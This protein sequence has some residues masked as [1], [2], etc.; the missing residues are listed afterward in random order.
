MKRVGILGLFFLTLNLFHPP[1]FADDD[2]DFNPVTDAF[3]QSLEKL[4]K[5][6]QELHRWD[7]SVRGFRHAHNFSW[8]YSSVLSQ[9]NLDGSLLEDGSEQPYAEVYETN[10]D[11]LG[12]EY[13]FHLHLFD[14]FGY[15]LGSSLGFSWEERSKG[16]NLTI[17]KA[18]TFP[19]AVVGLSLNLSPAVRLLTDLSVNLTRFERFKEYRAGVG[20]SSKIYFNART[21]SWK[22]GFDFF[23]KLNW[24]VRLAWEKFE[25]RYKPVKGSE[26]T[27]LGIERVQKGHKYTLGAVFHLL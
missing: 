7:R 26:L 21:F 9:W 10:Q 12:F 11:Y 27:E 14:S 13:T 15:Y 2:S 24:A 1:V 25:T 20:D 3:R 17:E 6:R 18:L 22:V 19:G 5:F 8:F 23:F 4:E 16:G